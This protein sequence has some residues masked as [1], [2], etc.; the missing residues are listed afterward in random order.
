MDLSLLSKEFKSQKILEGTDVSGSNEPDRI[1]HLPDG[2]LCYI[3]SFLPT[4]FAART[5]VLSTRW[6]DLWILVPSLDFEINP[7]DNYKGEIERFANFVDRLLVIRDHLSIREFRFACG[8]RFDFERLYAW[9]WIVI[10]SNIQVLH[11]HV[12]SLVAVGELPWSLF[13]SKSLV[14]LKLSGRFVLAIPFTV[15]LPSLKVLCLKSV[16]YTN[17]VSIEKLL[18]CCPILED[19]KISRERWDNCLNSVISHPSLKRLTFEFY[20][21]TSMGSFREAAG[22]FKYKL[23]VKA[24]NL[25]YLKLEDY[26]SDHI[27]VDFMPCLNEADISVMNLKKEDYWTRNQRCRY[28]RSICGMLQNLSKVK[29]LSLSGDTLRGIRTVFDGRLLIFHNLVRLVLGYDYLH[30]PTLLPPLL[31]ACPKLQS[32]V[33]PDGM[34]STCQEMGI[35]MD[36]YVEY[37]WKPPK[38]VPE[39]LLFTLKNIEIKCFCG[40]EPE[41][42]RLVKFLLKNAV[43]LEK[44]TLFCHEY[45]DDIYSFRDELMSYKRGSA[46][47]QLEIFPEVYSSAHH[48]ELEFERGH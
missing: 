1:S 28:G 4:K 7:R 36:Q 26:T 23:S 25:E 21:D 5:A 33:L 40:E 29:H 20:G 32:I 6:K 24:P 11:L 42:L 39:C 31:G 2:L 38:D 15:S 46:A 41:E 22:R 35:D 8:E 34:T 45:C 14:V 48:Y 16:I 17:D 27:L 47:C 30:G 10:M 12:E 18:S 44:M 9:M 3:L 37:R 43:V 13:S 19:L